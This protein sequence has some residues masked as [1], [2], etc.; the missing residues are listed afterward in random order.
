MNTIR[1]Y[2]I[3]LLAATL[4]VAACV[5]VDDSVEAPERR[6]EAQPEAIGFAAYVNRGETRGGVAGVLSLPSLK[7]AGFGVYAYYTGTH[8][9]DMTAL[10][11]FMH[12][13]RVVW[14]EVTSPASWTYSPTK[15]WP[16]GEGEATGVAGSIPHYVS[17]F[18]YAP[19]TEV[20]EATG[21][22]A[23]GSTTGIT[24]LTRPI[25]DGYPIARYAISTQ[26]A[27][28][29]DLCWGEPVLNATKPVGDAP[30]PV[31]FNF[32]HALS[33]LNVQ[34]D[35][36]IDEQ[37]GHSNSLDT[38]TRIWVRSIT[39]EGFTDQ[40][41]LNLKDGHWYN[42]DC[43][44]AVDKLPYTIYDGRIDGHEGLGADFN[45]RYT[46]LNPAIVQGAP[47]DH[48]QLATQLATTDAALT[49]V[50]NTAVNLFD[51]STWP[52]ADP[53]APT[54]EE[55]AAALAAP[56]YVIPNGAPLRV[57]IT[58][59]VETYDPKLITNHLGDAS[60][61]GSSIQN[62]ISTYITTGGAARITMQTGK[63]YSVHLHLGMRS[64]KVEA[65]VT[66]W[67]YGD[68]APIEVPK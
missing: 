54:T 15:Y 40:G 63:Q 59:D 13:E 20:S 28:G 67:V 12:N 50:T 19:Y 38:Y 31:T 30:S 53:A 60:T 27:Q 25:D 65:T 56:I 39:F 33:A 3:L 14:Q 34:I 42:P 18:A 10:S 44:C 4:T 22:V 66:P 35:A 45:E 5:S 58:Y 32:H 11:N 29:V 61:P 46:G 41:D 9:Y 24:A 52:Y 16:N 8:I 23:D 6:Q 2:A 64:V 43:D 57:S 7:T 21:C 47:Y 49:G 68:S 26:P 37:G 51:V 36:D 48:T 55:K 62:T 17:F 1:R